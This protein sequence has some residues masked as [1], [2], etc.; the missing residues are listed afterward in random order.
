MA[1]EDKFALGVLRIAAAHPNGIASFGR[2]RKEIPNFVKLSAAD[3]APSMTRPGEPMWHQIIRNIKSH[4]NDEGNFIYE[5]Y[6]KH[7]PRVGYRIT[8]TGLAHLKNKGLA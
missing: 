7:V 1:L 8:P 4:S 3:T 2:A 5:G 6:L